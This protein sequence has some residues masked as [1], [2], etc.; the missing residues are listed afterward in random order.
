VRKREKERQAEVQRR[1]CEAGVTGTGDNERKT[2]GVASRS[3]VA[4]RSASTCSRSL[5]LAREPLAGSRLPDRADGS[6]V[7]AAVAA[8]AAAGEGVSRSRAHTY[9]HTLE[10][11]AGAGPHPRSKEDGER[12]QK[13]SWIAAEGAGRAERKKASVKL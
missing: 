7:E 8:A 1:A 10:R 3:A 4:L 9:T 13:V 11:G 5:A 6:A 12:Q 2:R